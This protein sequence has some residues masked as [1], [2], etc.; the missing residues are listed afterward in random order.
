LRSEIRSFLRQRALGRCEYCLSVEDY[1]PSG[2][3]VEH[4]ISKFSGG[5]DD[6][7]NLAFACSDCNAFKGIHIVFDDPSTGT[8]AALFNPRRDMW[9][10][11][12]RWTDG[13]SIMLGKTPTGR[14]TIELLRLNR[15]SVVRLRELMR[16][17]G[18][19]PPLTGL[20]SV[21]EE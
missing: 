10:E 13:E 15:Q 6:P 1:S 2:F 20:G 7:E 4:I 16:I 11:H 12:F 5:T 14:A 19:H 18:L 8:E 9:E 3:E 17:V 21:S